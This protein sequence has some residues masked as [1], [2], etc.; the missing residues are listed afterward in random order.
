MVTWEKFIFN[1][2][3]SVFTVNVFKHYFLTKKEYFYSKN[4]YSTLLLSNPTC[5][6]K[7]SVVGQ[8]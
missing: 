2:K 5:G 4:F 7:N 6:S 3:K 1:G 8:L